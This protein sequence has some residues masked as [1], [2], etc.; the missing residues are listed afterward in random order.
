MP[1]NNFNIILN[2]WHGAGP[3]YM[4][5]LLIINRNAHDFPLQ[6]VCPTQS[7]YYRKSCGYGIAETIV[8]H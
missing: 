7:E 8:K 4:K 2:T 5:A 3:K 6:C 1:V